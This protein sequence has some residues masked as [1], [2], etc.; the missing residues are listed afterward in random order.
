MLNKNIIHLLAL[1][2]VATNSADKTVSIDGID[3]N[4]IDWNYIVNVSKRQGVSA[5]LIDAIKKIPSDQRPPKPL[6]LQWIGQMA[7]MEQMYNPLAELI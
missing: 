5:I 4:G 1:T 7:M 3:L 6:L 2:K